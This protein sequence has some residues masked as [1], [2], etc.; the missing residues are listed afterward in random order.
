MTIN[1]NYPLSQQLISYCRQHQITLAVAESCSGGYLS[2]SL[3]AIS[4]SSEVFDCGF[5]TYSNAEKIQ[6]LNVDPTVLQQHGAVSQPVA[7]AMAK[8]ALDNSNAD[9]TISITGITGPTGGSTEKPVGTVWLGLAQRNPELLETQQ[10][11]LSSGRKHIQRKA[12]QRAL[13]WLIIQCYQ[14]TA[15]R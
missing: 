1:F 11:L 3:T 6:C 2:H 5:I 8:G 4:G 10:C 7:A 15:Q 13:E 9:I 12:T 14:I